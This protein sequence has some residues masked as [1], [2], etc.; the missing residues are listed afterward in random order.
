MDVSFNNII[1]TN[2]KNASV[3]TANSSIVKI[4]NNNV[5]FDVQSNGNPY[6]LSCEYLLD[7]LLNINGTRNRQF[8]TDITSQNILGTNVSSSTTGFYSIPFHK[9]DM[10][11]LR[12][13]YVPFSDTGSGVTVIGDNKIYTR[14]YKIVLNCISE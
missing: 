11:S 12:L 2:I 14:S 9:G 6:I 7:G 8:L 4:N 3:S 1:N 10:I 5:F 13:N